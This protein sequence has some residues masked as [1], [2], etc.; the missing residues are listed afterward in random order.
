MKIYWLFCGLLLNLLVITP[1]KAQSI[2]A[3]DDDNNAQLQEINDLF[4][5]DAIDA[6]QDND[7]FEVVNRVI[8]DMNLFVSRALIVPPAKVY[9]KTLPAPVKESVANFYRNFTAPRIVINDLLQTNF[10]LAA[11]NTGRFAINT[12][13][14]VGGLFDVAAKYNYTYQDNNLDK[15]LKFYGVPSGPY[16]VLPFMPPANLRGALSSFADSFA[17][18]DH[19]LFPKQAIYKYSLKSLNI[20]QATAQNYQ[21]I[22]SVRTDNADY[23]AIIRSANNQANQGNRAK[24]T[25]NFEE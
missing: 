20:I 10:A 23:Y 22:E 12:T 16:I 4:G 17:E 9:N 14:G 18:I 24:T 5:Y 25:I 1:A 6:K 21:L 11:R 15:S 19:Y 2:M 8:L 3:N 13:I 7:P